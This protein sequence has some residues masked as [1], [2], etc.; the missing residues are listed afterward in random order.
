MFL[1]SVNLFIIVLF[2]VNGGWLN[3]GVWGKCLKICGVGY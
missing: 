2:E 1:I 3:W